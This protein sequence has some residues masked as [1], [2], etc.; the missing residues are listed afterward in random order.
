VDQYGSPGAATEDDKAQAFRR[1]YLRGLPPNL[2]ALRAVA[3]VCDVSLTGL[4]G[5]NLSENLR[6]Y[7][8]VFDGKRSIY[9]ARTTP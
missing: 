4:D 7:H 1:V 8:E 3:S 2:K 9:T 6:G 5:H